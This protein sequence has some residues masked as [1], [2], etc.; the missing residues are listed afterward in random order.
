MFKPT[1]HYKEVSA[2]VIG[3]STY[4]FPVDHPSSYVSNTTYTR[5]SKVVAHDPE[6]GRF[7]TKN[8]IY[9]PLNEQQTMRG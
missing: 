3:E 4:V 9:V 2:I 7:E 8:T 6:T 1:V 5:T